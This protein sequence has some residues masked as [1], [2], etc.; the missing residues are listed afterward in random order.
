MSFADSRL[1]ITMGMDRVSDE[2]RRAATTSHPP[3]PASTDRQDQIE[4]LRIRNLKR[5]LARRRGQN[6]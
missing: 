4:R 5:D 1:T 2:D 6:P 3:I